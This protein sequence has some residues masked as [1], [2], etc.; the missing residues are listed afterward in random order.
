MHKYIL[1]LFIIAILS[2]CHK[3]S[4]NAPSPSTDATSPSGSYAVKFDIA[5]QSVSTVVKQDSLYLTYHEKL[6]FLLNPDDYKNASAFH[7]KEDFS[8]T[9]LNGYQYKILNEDHLYRYNSVDDNL[10]NNVPFLTASTVT[11]SGVKYTKLILQRD[12]IFYKAY[13]LQ[14][15]AT[16]AQTNILKIS[17]DQVSFSTWYYHDK[18]NSDLATTNAILTYSKAD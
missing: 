17:T 7:V 5:V 14:Q 16:E 10:N 18:K 4:D 8:K 12:F 15:L 13:K 3:I 11:I 6:T 9:N 2:G 1:P